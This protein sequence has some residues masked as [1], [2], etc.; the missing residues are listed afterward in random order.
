VREYLEHRT[1]GECSDDGQ[2]TGSKDFRIANVSIFDL[3]EQQMCSLLFVMIHT[4]MKVALRKKA[5][6]KCQY[7]LAERGRRDSGPVLACNNP[8]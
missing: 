1:V 6:R 8:E 5:G 4:V 2:E 7:C 3:A